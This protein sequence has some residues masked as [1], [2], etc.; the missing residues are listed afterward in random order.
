MKQLR[1]LIVDDD[2]DFA[3]ALEEMLLL[4]RH[5]VETACTGEEAIRIARQRDFDITLMDVRMPGVGGVEA[6]HEIKK[7]KPNANIVMITAHRGVSVEKTIAKGA[8]GVLHKPFESH[9]L[10]SILESLTGQG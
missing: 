4:E 9:E 7:M 3:E 5:E 10:Y 8:L 6:F 2:S 1:I